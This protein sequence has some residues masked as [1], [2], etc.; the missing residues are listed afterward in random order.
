[1]KLPPSILTGLLPHQPGPAQ[2]LADLWEHTPHLLD[3]SETGTGKTYVAAAVL[4]ARP[5]PTLVLCPKIVVSAWKEA[6]NHF[7]DSVSSMGIEMV[8]T[9]RTPFGRWKNQPPPGYLSEKFF[10]CQCCQR[11]VDLD[12]FE[13]CYAHHLG[14]HCLIP[15]KKEW[16]YGEFIW[17]RAVKRIVFDEAHRMGGIDTLNGRMLVSAKRQGIQTLSLTATPACSPLNLWG[18]GEL[19]GL[20]AG[21][22]DFY[23]WAR[24][25]RCGTVPGMQGFRWLA[26]ADKQVGIMRDIHHE[27]FPSRGVCVRTSDIPG[28]PERIVTADC[29]DIENPQVVD[30]LYRSMA[31]ALA[32]LEEKKS[33]DADPEHPLTKILRILQ[34]LE[35]M[36]VPVAEELT[37]DY[38][39][40]GYSVA[41]FVNYRQTV[42]E[43]CARLHTTCLIDGRQTGSPAAR[44][45]CIENFQSNR[46]RVIVANNEAGGVAVSL[47]DKHGG[48]PRVGLVMPMHKVTSLKQVLGRLPRVGGK[49]PA[50]YKVILAAGT[51]EEQMRRTLNK[52]VNSLDSLLTG[53]FFPDFMRLSKASTL[54]LLEEKL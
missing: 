3:G 29:Y 40:K 45:E 15:K 22:P 13:P 53:D 25:H 26:G 11:I 44:Q 33:F 32:A 1:L 20:H 54:D 21:G 23:R 18:L 16:R 28:F 41:L 27:I 4:A 9:G 37:R 5:L 38:L 34:K 42:D 35:L 17:N 48:H 47:H 36:K 51:Y 6:A 24:R 8:R 50:I 12:K 52:R 19:L 31:D 7:G 14:I 2:H 39:A 30:S 46:S 43:L 49:S 10:K